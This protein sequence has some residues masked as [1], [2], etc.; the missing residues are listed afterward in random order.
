MFF[1]ILMFVIWLGMDVGV[2]YCGKY[3][4]RRDLTYQERRRFLELLM[5]LDMGPRT[6]LVMMVP[7]GLQR[8]GVDPAVASS[9]LLTTITDV[10]G[11]FVFLGLA[12]VFLL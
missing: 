7:L 3:T 4:T 5:L 8:V 2:Y 6:A 11:F 9:V 10:V 1:H 12:A